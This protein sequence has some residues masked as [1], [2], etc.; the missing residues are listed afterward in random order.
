MSDDFVNTD[1]AD[2][3]VELSAEE[4]ASLRREHNREKFAPLFSSESTDWQT[5]AHLFNALNA[6]FHFTLDVCATMENKKVRV[7]YSIHQDAFKLQW[8]GRCWCNP[9]YSRG[10]GRWL[11]KAKKSAVEN[12]ATVVMLLPSR[13]DTN[14]WFDHARF[15]EV[16]FLK[17][18]LKFEGA[19]SAA[20]FPS[21]LVIFRPGLPLSTSY[22][23]YR[24]VD[25][26]PGYTALQLA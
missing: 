24:Q 10:I 14:W 9:P 22:W 18:R 2:Y 17:G 3:T 16:R 19:P 7:F 20:P 23:D 8:R 25:Y 5:P 6:E 11:E 1:V 26:E 15:G 4:M 12:D 21:A 13:T